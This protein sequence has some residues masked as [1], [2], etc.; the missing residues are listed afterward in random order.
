MAARSGWQVMGLAVDTPDPVKAFLKKTPLDFPLALAGM[1]GS[2]LGRQ[3]GNAQGGLP[4]S[5]AFDAR[6]EV[7]WRKIGS[8]SLEELRALAKNGAPAKA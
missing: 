4:F 8:T 6:G 2:S 3:L 5:V 7:I 1:S